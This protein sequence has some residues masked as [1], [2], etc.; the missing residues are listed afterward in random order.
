L[1]GIDSCLTK[2]LIAIEILENIE[3]NKNVPIKDI[4]QELNNIL[5]IKYSLKGF[6]GIK[7]NKEIHNK[8]FIDFLPYIS[9]QF[10][11]PSKV[12]TIHQAKGDEF[13]CVMV[14]FSERDNLKLETSLDKYLFRAVENLHE[15]NNDGEEARLRYV[16][17]SRAKEYLFIHVPRCTEKEIKK[18]KNMGL[19]IKYLKTDN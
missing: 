10:D 9:K 1:K 16:A 3:S 13:D 17:F 12:R 6:T 14:C 4:F 15:D 5:K 8:K 19:E 2:R 11:S 7:G 18:F